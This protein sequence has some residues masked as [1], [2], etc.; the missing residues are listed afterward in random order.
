MTQKMNMTFCT[1]ALARV[2][3]NPIKLLFIDVTSELGVDVARG[4]WAFA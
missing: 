2:T 1:L 4:V 3:S